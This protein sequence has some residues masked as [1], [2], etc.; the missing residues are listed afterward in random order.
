MSRFTSSKE[1]SNRETGGRGRLLRPAVM[2]AVA[3][4]E[5]GALWLRA[6]KLGGRVVVRCRDGHLFTT[7]WIPG[8]SV[9]ALRLGW[10]R[11]QRC[12][13][14]RHWSLV[15]PVRESELSEEQRRLAR[16]QRDAPLP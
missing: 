16:E 1:D 10:W 2:V 13:V 9:K 5:S 8:A 12:P 15:T 3:A 11:F 7:L 4:A 6:G 14:G